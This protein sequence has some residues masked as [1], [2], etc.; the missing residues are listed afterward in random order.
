MNR[1]MI[2]VPFAELD[3][4]CLAVSKERSD[5]NAISLLFCPITDDDFGLINDIQCRGLKS[6]RTDSG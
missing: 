5:L 6:M 1:S 2:R 4:I 3:K